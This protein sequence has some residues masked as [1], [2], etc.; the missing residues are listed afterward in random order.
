MKVN[1]EAISDEIDDIIL[2]GR[3]V[4]VVDDDELFR[5]HLAISLGQT[6]LRITE[7]F[8]SASLIAVL[9]KEMPDCILLD[10]KLDLENG[11]RM[12]EQLQQRFTNLAPVIMMSAD[13]SQR[14]AIKA[15][16]L[17]LQDFL[18][19]RNLHLDQVTYAIRRSIA[20]HEMVIAHRHEIDMLRKKS[21]FDDLTGL[22][23]RE[24]LDNKLATIKTAAD[25]KNI[26]FAI[27]AIHM[28]E[29]EQ[30]VTQLGPTCSDEV[31]R[32]FANR[33]RQTIRQED[34]C[35]RW[36][37][38][39]FY[40][41]VSRNQSVSYLK[42][43]TQRFESDLSFTHFHKSAKL[44]ITSRL[45]YAVYPQH[46][47]TLEEISSYLTSEIEQQKIH[48]GESKPEDWKV[49]PQPGIDTLTGEERRRAPRKRVF[50]S[51]V[52]SME[53]WSSRISCTVRNISDTGARLRMEGPVPLPRYFLLQISDTGPFRKVRKC[54]HVD[55]EV[56]VEFCDP[57]S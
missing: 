6:N 45:A 18:P 40:Y 53:E 3:S 39:T 29:H 7:A 44:Q 20:R 14:T 49:L 23:R 24:E 12:H 48:A 35:G 33:L 13:E 51:A 47:G 28:T 57:D 21:M 8:D 50:K 42:E 4:C 25:L 31:L 52:I 22:Y 9:E 36:D 5:K 32:V 11:F 37:E 2:D 43:R 38:D 19:K 17:G 34:F 30:I 15:F 46:G 27:I 54:W 56:G 26:P 10:Y 1:Y 16:R 41:I 55:N